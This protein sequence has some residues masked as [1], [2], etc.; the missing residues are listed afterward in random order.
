MA[1]VGG[2]SLPKQYERFQAIAFGAGTDEEPGTVDDLRLGLVD[3]DWGLEE[4]PV[5]FD[6]DDVEFVGAI[7]GAGLFTPA[8]DGPNPARSGDRNNVGDVWVTATYDP[9]IGGQAPLEARGQLVVTVPLYLRW[10][11]SPL[12]VE[13]EDDR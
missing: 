13:L 12:A 1:R 8:E 5:S 11:I 10:E 2:A 4:Y 9:G 6:D 7:D 3:V